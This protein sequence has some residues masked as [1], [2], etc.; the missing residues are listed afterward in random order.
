MSQQKE[1]KYILR[2][3]NPEG[4]GVIHKEALCHIAY[5]TALDALC[6]ST[7]LTNDQIRKFTVKK[8]N[9]SRHE[10]GIDIEV[11]VPI[12]RDLNA[13]HLLEKAQKEIQQ[14]FS[15]FLAIKV[16][17]INIVIDQVLF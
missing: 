9:F 13:Y 10:D 15:D 3:E 6:V 12:K 17:K 8:T 11:H 14:N 7:F 16:R 1:V 5:A 4:V 2:A